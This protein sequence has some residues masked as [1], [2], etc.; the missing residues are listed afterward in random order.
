MNTSGNDCSAFPTEQN[1]RKFPSKM[2]TLVSLG[3][4]MFFHRRGDRLK[5]RPTMASVNRHDFTSV[6][7]LQIPKYQNTYRL[8]SFDSFNAEAVDKIVLQVM[9]DKLSTVTSYQPSEMGKLCK[10]IGAELQKAI[11]KKDYDRYKIVAQV[12]IAQR[13]DQSV[14]AAFQCLWDVERDNYSYYVYENNHIYAWCCVF[15]IYYE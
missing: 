12:T 15:G 6:K 8:E 14:H 3:S 2:S 5:V 13:L 1:R 7:C 11:G 10:E 4:R 9:E